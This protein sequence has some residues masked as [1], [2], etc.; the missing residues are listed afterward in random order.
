VPSLVATHTEGR[1][2]PSRRRLLRRPG[3]LVPRIAIVTATIDLWIQVTRESGDCV[4][5]PKQWAAS[6]CSGKLTVRLPKSLHRELVECGFG[7]A[8]RAADGNHEG[9]RLP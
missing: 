1:E 5:E 3:R 4:P 2:M 9:R 6:T 8:M 7:T